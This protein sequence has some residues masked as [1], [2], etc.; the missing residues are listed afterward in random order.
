M[1]EFKLEE[2]A[3]ESLPFPALRIIGVLVRWQ[4]V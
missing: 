4:Q 1:M 3:M 2:G